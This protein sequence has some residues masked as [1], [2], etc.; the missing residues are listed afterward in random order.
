MK[1]D[2]STIHTQMSRAIGDVFPCAVLRVTRGEEILYF[3]AH[4]RGRS[5]LV[6]LPIITTSIFD[7]AS[8]T[9]SMVIGTIAMKGVEEGWLDLNAPVC[10]VLEMFRRP[11]TRDIRLAHLLTHCS[12]LPDWRPYLEWIFERHPKI[13][14]GTPACVDRVQRW[15]YREPLI[16]KPGEKT[17][18]S[19]LGYMMLGWWLEKRKSTTL[20]QLFQE[21]VAKPLGLRDTRYIPV[22][23]WESIGALFDN[24]RIVTTEV[25]PGRRRLLQGEVHDENAFLLGGVAGHAGLFSTARDVGIWAKA[26]LSSNRKDGYLPSS[27]VK[28]FWYSTPA[29]ND[30]TWRHAFDGPSKKGS[31]GG[32]RISSSAVCH[33]GFTGCSVWID[34]QRDMTVVLL[35]NR[36]HPTRDNEN[37][38]A[39]RPALHDAIWDLVDPK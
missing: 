31:S 18:Y 13:E 33:L 38:K 8:V 7:L 16:G 32:K 27:V 26:L 28:Q 22:T 17:V 20:S 39:F 14:P 2:F 30:S 35:S 29:N 1:K 19:D 3:E 24:P 4:G 37:I 11:E 23:S 34:P 21:M 9:K 10:D 15:I 12:G 6:G 36:V 5:D 25:C